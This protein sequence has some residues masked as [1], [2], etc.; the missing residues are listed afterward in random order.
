M[1]TSFCTTVA[2]STSAG[3]GGA[4]AFGFRQPVNSNEAAGSS[5]T[6]GQI[7]PKRERD[8]LL[9]RV[10]IVICIA[11]IPS[12]NLAGLSLLADSQLKGMAHMMLQILPEVH[13]KPAQR[14]RRQ[15][16]NSVGLA[17]NQIKRITQW[18]KETGL[19]ERS[20][21]ELGGHPPVSR[22]RTARPHDRR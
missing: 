2:T 13:T 3:G 11:E 12:L 15:L 5:A 6:M 14:P 18:R 21:C 22:C 8:F 9:P 17:L 16:G 7:S 1:G 20:P 10:R 19:L 4:A